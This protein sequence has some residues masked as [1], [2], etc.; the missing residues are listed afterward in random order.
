MASL[1][2]TG[3]TMTVVVLNKDPQNTAQVQ[4]NFNG[5][6]PTSVVSYTFSSTA[7]SAIAP[8]SPQSWTSTMSFAPY[9]ATL[10]VITGSSTNT[11]ASEWD[12][13][14]DTIMV[15][16]NGSVTLNPR[17]I[18][19]TANVSLS[20]A[21]FD[22]YE[23]ASACTGG[24]INITGSTMTPARVNGTIVVDAPAT[25]GFCHFTVTGSDTSGVAQTQGGWIV[26]GN[27]A[28]QFTTTGSG[29]TGAGG[30]TLPMPLTV[31]LNPGQSGG[32]AA[33]ASIFFTVISGGG[34]LSN[35]TTSG[36]KVIAVT[37]SSGVAS[38]TLTLPANSAQVQV[39][40]EGE[41]GLGHPVALFT[42]TAQ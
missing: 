28:A 21:G 26:V 11:P 8:S 2:S 22:S 23:G 35:G 17:I 18:T 9:S 16:A 19:G 4:F 34:T 6:T 14:P 15:P 40:A 39:Q 42:E 10:L 38:V 5:Y 3:K 1:D 27:P 37:N 7:P 30:S 33:G 36:P 25:P 20:S 31:T 12:L 29:Q 32:V 24:S 41:Y 13:N